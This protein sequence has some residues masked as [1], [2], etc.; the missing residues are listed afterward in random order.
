MGRNV[1][2][3]IQSFSEII[4]KKYF[5]VDKTSFIKEW[6]DSGDSVTLITRPRRFGKTLNMSMV[7]QFF[8]L[9]YANRG[10]LFEGLSIW[11][12]KEYRE[13]QGTY[14]VISL[15]FANIKEKNYEITRKKICQILTDLYADYTFLM[16]S[17][18]M[19]AS[20]REFFH[21]IS[22]DMGDVEA[23]L[24]LHNLSKYL[25]RY[26]GK[27]VII[28]LDEYDTPMQEAYVDGYWDELVVFTR[29]LF[30]STFK[31]NPWLDRAIMT[32]ITRV[33]KESIFSDLNNLEVVTTT[34]NKYATSFGFTEEEVFDALE[35]CE[36]SGEKKEVKR[37]YDGFIFGKQ[38]DIYNPWSILNFLDKKDYRTYWANT[39]SNSLVGKLLR[40]GD[41]RIKEQFEILLD[42]GVIESPI[43]E[44]IV[45]N[46]L[47]GNERAIWSLLLA[48]GYLKVLRFES[49]IEVP[50]G[51]NPKYTLALTNREVRLMFQNMIRDWFMD[52]EGDYNDFIKALLLGNKKVMNRYMNR[53]ALNVFSYFDTGKRPS[54]E[55]P[56]RFYHGFVLGLIV[57]LQSRYVITSNRESG[58]GRYDV[59]LE[60]KNPQKD[61]TIIMEF[62]VHDPDDEDTLED[63][64][65]SALAQIEEKQYEV[66][67]VARGIPA[68]RIRKYG[69]AFEGKKVLI[70]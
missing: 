60:A 57:D 42:G 54:G 1:A 53:I 69:F 47:R 66:D 17:D 25:S 9:D 44:Q 13:I 28:L 52:V 31:T 70:G 48:S 3:G 21:R 65:A 35:E 58:F 4:E 24:A 11:K 23:T 14:P 50:D 38:K 6:W 30:N 26:Y 41:R 12:E 33:S 56:E 16:K 27:K 39:S 55:E 34:S 19:E 20:D 40:E 46:Q 43:D 36:L 49:I 64:V 8:S 32:G 68:E 29:S 10:D 45:Y 67:L 63:T 5:Y 61:D 2:I 37:W 59:V 51:T 7:E 22:P 62:K 15:S 18:V